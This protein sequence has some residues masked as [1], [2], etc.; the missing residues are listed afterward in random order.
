[1]FVRLIIIALFSFFVMKIQET[2]LKLKY[3]NL[4]KINITGN[5][6]MLQTELTSLV[7][8]L[9]NKNNFDID[10]SELK[11]TLENDVRLSSVEIKEVGLG[12]IDINV[13]EKD[14]SYYAIIKK[15]VYLVDENGDLFGYIN[16]KKKESVPLIVANTREEVK[17]LV[18]L[19]NKVHE[20]QLFHHISQAYK[21]LDEE[22]IIVLRD[23][24]KIKTD[25]IVESDKYRILETLYSEMKK[26]K[27]IDYIDLRF[28]DYII[29]Y[30]GDEWY[31]RQWNNQICFGYREP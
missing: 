12:E 21:K 8:N 20:R 30:M 2:F 6:K 7:N 4:T 25:L 18:G 19:L 31:E 15:E 17:E 13:E 9:Y 28:D 16:E 27:K 5:A 24:T 10:Y 1:M 26:N 3:F 14:F 11:K 23:G 22:Y 29:K